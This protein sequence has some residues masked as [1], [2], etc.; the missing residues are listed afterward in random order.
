[1][2]SI[3]RR[4]HIVLAGRCVPLFLVDPSGTDLLDA[5]SPLFSAARAPP[6]KHACTTSRLISASNT[7]RRM[8]D[9]RVFP[10]NQD[11]TTSFLVPTAM[12]PG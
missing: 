7:V 12:S 8:S 2:G 4:T 1:M 9:A 3:K 5:T 10:C 6:A 11:G